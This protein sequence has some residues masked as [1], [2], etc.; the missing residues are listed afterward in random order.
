[1]AMPHRIRSA[2]REN[3]LLHRERKIQFGFLAL[4]FVSLCLAFPEAR[5]TED[6]DLWQGIDLPT[7]L[8]ESR[9][10]TCD[11]SAAHKKGCEEALRYLEEQL[12]ARTAEGFLP[13]SKG[14]H[15]A[16][17]SR[18][19]SDLL[20]LLRQ[21]KHPESE[22]VAGALNAWLSA[23]DPHAKIVPAEGSERVAGTPFIAVNGIG[24]KLRIFQEKALVAYVME[25]SGGESS[26]I[27][28]GDEVLK[29]NGISLHTLSRLGKERVFRAA[30]AP[31]KL[32]LRRGE[33]KLAIRADERRFFLPNVEWRIRN[34]EAG[35]RE[36]LV[37][38]RSFTKESTCADIR[39]TLEALEKRNVERIELDLR[40]NPG[41][42]VREAQCAAGLF[43]GAGKL[44]ARM[45]KSSKDAILPASPAGYSHANEAEFSLFTDQDRIT[46]KPL[47]VRINQNTASAAEML[48]AALQDEGRAQIFGARSFG[49]GSMQSVFHPWNDERLYFTRTTHR[50]LRPSGKGLNLAGV[51][52]DIV[53][54]RAEGADFPREADLTQ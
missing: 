9:M 1:M 3:P 51:T 16:A 5:E 27:R 17:K 44:F 45:Q 35:V 8:L 28:A 32:L 50:I 19:F 20:L 23:F 7:S 33:R 30:K 4:L 41:G 2:N 36:A 43:L 10:E 53:T 39:K 24:V 26:G 42:L 29:L 40:D 54:E 6:A 22:W 15:A 11:R 38:V 21:Q 14:S 34:S 25:G 47:L 31:F 48:A 37:R 46:A 18:K 52:P 49:K 13:T 12:R